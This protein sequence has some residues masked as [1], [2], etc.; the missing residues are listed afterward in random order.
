[1][2]GLFANVNSAT[3]S[4]VTIDNMQIVNESGTTIY[5]GITKNIK[6]DISISESI[7]IAASLKSILDFLGQIDSETFEF[8]IGEVNLP[9]MIKDKNFST[10]VMPISL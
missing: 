8:C 6:K 4:D 1:M 2:V 10:I 3:V 9:F 5:G 7:Q